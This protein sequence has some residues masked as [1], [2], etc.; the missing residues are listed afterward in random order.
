[1]A[2]SLASNRRPLLEMLEGHGLA[3][4]ATASLDEFPNAQSVTNLKIKP[5]RYP[6]SGRNGNTCVNIAGL[7]TEDFD[8]AAFHQSINFLSNPVLAIK[9]IVGRLKPN[10]RL[11]FGINKREFCPDVFRP[12]T[13]L[14]HLLQDFQRQTVDIS[15]EHMLA[16]VYAWNQAIFDDPYNISRVLKFMWDN[17]IEQIDRV[18]QRRIA[19][20]NLKTVE[21]IL[22]AEVDLCAQHVFDLPLIMEVMHFINLELDLNFAPIHVALTKGLLN[23]HAIVFENLPAAASTEDPAWRTNLKILEG[24]KRLYDVEVM[25]ENEF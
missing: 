9:E 7:K 10:G 17:E 6:S 25:L 3:V 19:K 13:S 21:K 18:V 24:F 4:N 2:V 1:M 15:D 22:D 11:Y 16:F 14:S 23:E 12:V 8:F 20:S 5:P